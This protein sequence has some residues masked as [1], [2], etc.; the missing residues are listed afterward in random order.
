MADAF[1]AVRSGVGTALVRAW[2][3]RRLPP[4]AAILDIGCGSGMPIAAALVADGFTIWGIDPSPRMIA[5]FRRRLPG[6]PAACEPA[7]AS[8]VFGRRFEGAI[9]VG[10]LF[11]LRPADQLALLRRVAGALVPGGHFLF[12]APRARAAWTD[13]LTGG[14]SVSL[15]VEAYAV[16]LADAGLRLLRSERDEGGND[17]HETIR[18]A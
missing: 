12:S 18:A 9:A 10:V 1:M 4:G 3:A 6:M 2:A 15:G 14:A 7:Q 17:Y 8:D 13:S 5:A 11:L 16:H